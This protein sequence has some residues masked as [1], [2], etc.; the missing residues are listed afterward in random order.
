M[1]PRIEDIKAHGKD[2]HKLMK[3]TFENI[4]PPKGSPKWSDYV[5]YCNNLVIEGITK[6]INSSLA[7]LADNISISWN[8]HNN[9]QPMFD[10][11]VDLISRQVM[12]DPPIGCSPSRGN[13]IRDIVFK[14]ID[15]FI[16]I[17]IQMPRLD[18]NSGDYLVEIK[19]QFE[20]YGAMQVVAN[21]LN[22]IEGAAAHFIDQYADQEFLW[23]ETLEENFQA[24]LDQGEDPR[25]K[26]HKRI[27][28]DGEEE[29]D[30]TFNWMAEKILQ[31]V[32]TKKPSLE[33][34][35]EKI[36]QLTK[37]KL[38]INEMKTTNDI[39]WIRV[40]STPLIKELQKTIVTWIDAYTNFLLE[41]TTNE[42]RNIEK[43][44]DDV[45]NGIK[46]IP[47]SAESKKEKELLM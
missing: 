31:G 45:F 32:E 34:F 29:E 7:H 16:S 6:G 28:A 38:Q 4:R 47:E 10:I 12:F 9:Q 25:E 24:F 43:F 27:N 11:K 42:L 19:D 14:I 21:N 37:V 46:V 26:V 15:G 39:G 13:G 18:T 40:N 1:Q 17:A 23:K 36:T 44:C 20:L 22:E 35:D 5:N 8:R 33:L 2:I 41:N 3:D 30:E